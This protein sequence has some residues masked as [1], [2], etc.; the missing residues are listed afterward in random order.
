MRLLSSKYCNEMDKAIIFAF[1]DVEFVF[2]FYRFAG[3]HAVVVKN[4]FQKT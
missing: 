2:N 3:L 1:S 4:I